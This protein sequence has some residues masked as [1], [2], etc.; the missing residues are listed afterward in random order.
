VVGPSE[1]ETSSFW[2]TY[3]GKCSIFRI[4]PGNNLLL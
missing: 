2:W 4:L 1:L 3:H